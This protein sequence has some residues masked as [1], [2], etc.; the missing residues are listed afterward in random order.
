VKALRAYAALA[1]AT[2]SWGIGTATAKYAVGPLGAFTT[3]VIELSAAALVLWL[4]MTIRACRASRASLSGPAGLSGLSGRRPRSRSIPLRRYLLL[5]LVEPVITYG[6]LDLG[7]QR[8]SAADAS[9]L[10]GLQS[11]IVLVLGVL[12]LKE[13]VTRRSLAGVLV[14]ALGGALLAGAHFTARGLLGDAL[15]LLGSLGGSW[16][17][18]LVSTMTEQADALELTAYQFGVGFVFSLPIAFVAWGTGGERMPGAGDLRYVAAA[19]GIGLVSFGAGYLAYNYGVARVPVG[20]AGMALNLIPLFGV[21]TAVLALGERLS[22]FEVIGGALII[23]GVA[24]F[25][26]TT[27]ES[28]QD[29]DPRHVGDAARDGLAR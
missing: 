28:V 29:L 7:L 10:D 23:A 14:A 16:S 13:A 1:F 27:K 12:L 9:L 11:C 5:G 20:A 4:A 6:A 24:V 22:V 15:V 25:P 2:A 17:V 8:T 3:L 21:T 26:Y 19:A 18:I